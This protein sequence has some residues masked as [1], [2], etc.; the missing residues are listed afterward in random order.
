MFRVPS[1]APRSGRVTLEG[2]EGR[3]AADVRR[4]RV[5][6][7]IWLTD[8]AGTRWEGAVG[9]VRR[10]AL[11]VDVEH[12]VSE[13]AASP[14]LVAVQALAK[15]GR[16]EAAIEAMTEI[17]VDEVVAWSASRS[18]AKWTD[19]TAAKWQSTVDAAAKQARRSWWPQVSGPASTADVAARI[20]AAD[21]ALVL[22]E[23]AG[24]AIP[25]VDIAAAGE[26]LVVIG[27]EGGIADDELEALTAAGGQPVRLGANVLR[28]STAGVAALA[29][30]CARTRWA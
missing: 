9:E 20:R 15:G 7:P 14:R 19:R 2:S 12:V 21:V 18:I 22:S 27:P 6:E 29:A 26:V 1:G 10:G 16:D 17:G 25:T 13:P 23:A 11:D 28:S 4:L 5:G 8:G 30:I 24:R 3:H